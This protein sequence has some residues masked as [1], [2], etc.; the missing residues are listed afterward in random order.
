MNELSKSDIEFI[1]S[2][3]DEQM[4]HEETYYDDFV[5]LVK[6]LIRGYNPHA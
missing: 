3:M 6:E 1:L 4:N 5:S 2:Y